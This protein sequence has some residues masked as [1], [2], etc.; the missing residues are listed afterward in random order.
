MLVDD[1]HFMVGPLESDLPDEVGEEGHE[2]ARLLLGEHHVW[3]RRRRR[4]GQ[5]ATRH[6]I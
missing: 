3:E 2:V 6:A 1:W 5:Q 4:S